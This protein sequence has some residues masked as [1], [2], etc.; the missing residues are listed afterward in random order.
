MSPAIWESLGQLADLVPTS[1]SWTILPL[2]MFLVEENCRRVDPND[3]PPDNPNEAHPEMEKL[4]ELT[5]MLAPRFQSAREHW[6]IMQ[7]VNRLIRSSAA[8]KRPPGATFSSSGSEEGSRKRRR[9][10][11]NVE[12]RE[13]TEL[14][15]LNQAMGFLDRSLAYGASAL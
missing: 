7:E 4:L 3:P 13:A 5:N 6:S 14:E 11:S 1:L 8:S 10:S 15:F 2:V 12:K 9:T